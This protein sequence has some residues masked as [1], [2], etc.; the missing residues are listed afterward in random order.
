[1]GK[2]GAITS[3]YMVRLGDSILGLHTKKGA[4]KNISSMWIYFSCIALKNFTDFPGLH[5]PIPS[6][7][8]KYLYPHFTDKKRRQKKVKW[9][10]N[11]LIVQSGREPRSHFR[12]K[13][14]LTL[15]PS[16]C[17]TV[18]AS[19]RESFGQWAQ[20]LESLVHHP[21]NWEHKPQINILWMSAKE[22]VLKRPSSSS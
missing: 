11:K 13:P 18:P 10:S 3:Q 17:C 6:E 14:E 20:D 1:M 8:E 9:L 21:K 4:V 7:T 19:D 12:Q 15:F 2:H 22:N 16:N 5:F